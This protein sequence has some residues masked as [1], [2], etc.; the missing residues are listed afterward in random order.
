MTV[1]SK[2]RQITGVKFDQRRKALALAALAEGG[3]TRSA[4]ARAA[5]ISRKTFYEHLEA[6]PEFL[7]A[8]VEAELVPISVAVDNLYKRVQG[9]EYTEDRACANGTVVQVR[10][11]KHP[12]LAAIQYFLNNRTRCLAIEERFENPA[13]IELTAPG[14]GPVEFQFRWSPPQVESADE[15]PTI[16]AAEERLAL[17][18]STE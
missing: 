13:R 4:A 14:G 9:Y 15:E 6:D 7:E 16:D 18:A 2:P 11:Y 10:L 3:C 8:V 1:T 17:P 5:G 12:D